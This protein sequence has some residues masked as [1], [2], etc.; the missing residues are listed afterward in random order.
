MPL[1]AVIGLDH[2]PHAMARRD[3]VRAEHRAYVR[4]NDAPIRLVGPLLDGDNNQCGSFYIFE[5]EDEQA[6]RAWLAAEPFVN[7]DVYK[8]IV[9]RRFQVG[10]NT[11]AP[12][13]WPDLDGQ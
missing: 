9:V 7:A 12:Q 5:A 13:D 10:L 11:L 4:S 6:V 2:P 8:D 1:F 3:A